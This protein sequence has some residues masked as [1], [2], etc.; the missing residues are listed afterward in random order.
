MVRGDVLGEKTRVEMMVSCGWIN[1]LAT[2]FELIVVEVLRRS[3]W[4]A[5]LLLP[6]SITKY[7][8]NLIWHY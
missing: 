2:R 6:S 3:Y 8:V 5:L 7:K 4:V 1:C